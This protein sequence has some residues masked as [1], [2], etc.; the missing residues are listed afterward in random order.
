MRCSTSLLQRT[1]RR[2]VS[3]RL[4]GPEQKRMSV[5]RGLMVQP[6]PQDGGGG[7][8]GRTQHQRDAGARSWEC[9]CAC[10]LD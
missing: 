2:L 6:Q 9:R 8:G 1:A 4:Q 3:D 5:C 10:R 7:G